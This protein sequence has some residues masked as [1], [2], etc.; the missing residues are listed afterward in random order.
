MT[1]TAEFAHAFADFFY[2]AV[3]AAGGSRSTA[4][5]CL[6]EWWRAVEEFTA[7]DGQE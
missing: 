1:D 2:R 7:K 4:H 6:A 5:K 3:L